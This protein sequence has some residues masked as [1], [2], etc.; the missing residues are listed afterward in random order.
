MVSGGDLNSRIRA[1]ESTVRRL[2]HTCIP[3]TLIYYAAPADTWIGI[4]R[5][6][7]LLGLLL[8]LIV[9][10]LVRLS[11]QIKI[12]GFRDYEMGTMGAYLWVGI[13]LTLAFLFFDFIFVVPAV[14]GMAWIDP[15][16]GILRSRE[17]KLYPWAPFVCYLAIALLSLWYLSNLTIQKTALIS[18]IGAISAIAAEHWKVMFIDDDFLMLVIPLALMTLVSFV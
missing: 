3:V 11:Y 6:L 8:F 4:D 9:F 13:G 17:S 1:E 7:I 10:E 18:V 14:L 2:V 5:T 16:N 15:L 12:F